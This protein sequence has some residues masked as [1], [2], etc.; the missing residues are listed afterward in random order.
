MKNKKIYFRIQISREISQIFF[1]WNFVRLLAQTSIHCLVL[2]SPRYLFLQPA[3][4]TKDERKTQ[5]CYELKVSRC[6]PFFSVFFCT[7]SLTEKIRCLPACHLNRKI[8]L[9]LFSFGEWT[10]LVLLHAHA[11]SAH[12]QKRG[13]GVGPHTVIIRARGLGPF[14]KTKGCRKSFQ[15]SYPWHLITMTP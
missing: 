11:F 5:K 12:I 9:G 2:G 13:G 6:Q 4:T 7:Q 8:N 1:A 3:F 15:G 14:H 10:Q